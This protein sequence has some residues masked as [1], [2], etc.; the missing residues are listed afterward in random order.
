VERPEIG[1]G[2]KGETNG[3]TYLKDN[4]KGKQKNFMSKDLDI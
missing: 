4:M 3:I 1:Q 2:P